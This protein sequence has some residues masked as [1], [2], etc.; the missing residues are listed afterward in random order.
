MPVKK[1]DKESGTERDTM[2]IDLSWCSLCKH[3]G[4]ARSLIKKMTNAYITLVKKPDF[5]YFHRGKSF[6]TRCL[7]GLMVN[8]CRTPHW[9]LTVK[10]EKLAALV[11]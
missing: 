9:Y 6:L 10:Y 2:V 1:R 4:I 8:T 7:A 3:L 5:I 11:E